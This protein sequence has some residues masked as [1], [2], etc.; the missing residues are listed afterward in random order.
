[1]AGPHLDARPGPRWLRTVALALILAVF[2]IILFSRMRIRS[3][4][5]ERDEGE[6][7]YAGQL[8]LEG[9]PPYSLACNMK[10]PGTYTV[11]AAIMAVFGQTISGIR[12][13][14]LLVNFATAWLIFL[15]GRRLFSR[16]AGIAAAAVYALL[17][18][19]PQVMGQ[20]AHATQF[21]VLPAVGGVLLLLRAID[22][23]KYGA[24]F[25][26]GVLFGIGYL[27]KQHGIF[28]A[29]FAAAWL[30]WKHPGGWMATARRLVVFGAAFVLPFAVTC[31]LLWQAGV[32]PKFW[33][34]TFQYARAYA[35]ENNLADGMENLTEELPSLFDRV[36]TLWGLALAGL[37][38]VWW[39]RATRETARFLTVFLLFSA[40]AVCP[41]LYFRDHYFVLML[42]AV[43]LAA[44]AL[45]G[46]LSGYGMAICALALAA[47]I[48][49]QTGY[50]FL[51][52]P[53]EVS[54]K[55]YDLN[56]FPEIIPVSAYIRDHS[57]PADRVVVLGSE[58]ELYFYSHRHSGT[59]YIY[60]FALT[61]DQPFARQ[62]TNDMIHDVQDGRPEY[63]VL[64][65]S[66]DL[67]AYRNEGRP[68][69]YSWWGGWGPS[70]YDMV[71][72]ADIIS[73]TRTE[74][75]WG[76]AAASYKPESDFI[77]AIYKRK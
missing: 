26:S 23:G 54:R 40:L 1:M 76:P 62:M 43:A 14:V 10:L 30:L 19:G 28:F 39:K 57:T 50:L 56:P 20:A 16:N 25:W 13:G 35:G 32:F 34:W 3:T 49:L 21:V 71:G 77:V 72:I 70:H 67:W 22:S 5:L 74:Y 51:W 48:V 4:P 52:T 47:G 61:E 7:A 38:A 63:V 24:L 41:G 46:V 8:M 64:V 33:F 59:G 55:I 27:M 65:D 68:T 12:I 53:F 6:Y 17:S 44:G 69:V 58:P 18:F 15:L 36:W 73:N 60:T 29:G 11:Y 37:I 2:P 42:P 66:I 31:L 9:I 75:R 45:A